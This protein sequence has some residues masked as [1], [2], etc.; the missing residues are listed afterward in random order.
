MP[1]LVLQLLLHISPQHCSVMYSITAAAA[2]ALEQHFKPSFVPGLMKDIHP[3]ISCMQWGF[4]WEPTIF[5]VYT[6]CTPFFVLNDLIWFLHRVPHIS[7]W[8]IL[9]MSLFQLLALKCDQQCE[10]DVQGWLQWLTCLHW[11]VLQVYSIS[12]YSTWPNVK[13]WTIV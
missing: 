4:G 9:S 8:G 12:A 5:P 2:V 10:T 6:S 13:L 1:K 11:A 7:F 3:N